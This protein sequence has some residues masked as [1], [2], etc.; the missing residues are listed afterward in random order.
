M[1][2][3]LFLGDFMKRFLIVSFMALLVGGLF[4]YFMFDSNV[5]NSVSVGSSYN[6]KA[7]QIGVFSREE[8]AIRVAALN[9]GIVVPEGDLYRVY[10]AIL[11]DKDAI[12]YLEEYYGSVGINYYI[13]D[14]N[15][16]SE[17]LDKIRESE[18]KIKSC[19]NKNCSNIALSILN[20][21]EESL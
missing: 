10:I 21:Y 1:L 2:C 12:S 5:S 15:V 13:R 20:K 18:E 6:A 4:A 16:S 17:F 14:I 11:N 8:N 7:F 9:Q 19:D 3:I